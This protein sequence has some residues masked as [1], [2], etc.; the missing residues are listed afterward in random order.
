MC[1]VIRGKKILTPAL[2]IQIRK[3]LSL[4]LPSGA[5]SFLDIFVIATSLFFIGKIDAF[6]IVAIGVSLN[7]LMLFF[8]INA[9][10]YIG[11]NAQISR[12]FG[13]KEYQ[14]AKDVFS[15]L[16]I[17]G[18]LISFPLIPLAYFGSQNFFTYLKIQEH[19][20]ALAHTYISFI[21]FTIPSLMLKT[22]I[23][24]ALAGIGDT[25]H[26]FLVRLFSTILC[27]VLNY[28]FIFGFLFIPPLGIFGAGLATLISA[29]IELFALSIM[30]YLKSDFLK[31]FRFRKQY[32]IK[33]LKIGTPAGI[34][35]FLTLFSLVLTTKFIALFG[36]LALAGT[37]I[38]TRIEAF[39][40][41][42]GF[43]FM[44]AAMVLMGQNLGAKKPKVAALYIRT[45]L[46]FSSITLGILGLILVCFAHPFSSIFS[47]NTTV[48]NVS[49]SYLIAVGLSQVPMICSFVYDGA[50][51]GSGF[52]QSVLLINGISIWVFRMLPIWILVHFNCKIQWIFVVIFIETYIRAIIFHF[53]FKTGIWK[54]RQI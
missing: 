39:S 50:L 9:I 47:K 19:T 26:P 18:F 49:I 37:Q 35:R 30:L 27:V 22:I 21:I 14:K 33:A 40:F 32:L 52:S 44:T 41:M 8:A 31:S 13:A 29:Y 5:N 2:K 15:S 1:R 48:I 10:F 28:L 36:D 34:E 53:I 38:G 25:L 43:G 54:N 42:P 51:R 11:T 6:H 7:F 20:Q 45:I 4:A 3:I 23:I 12:Y 17:G 24:S 46:I 16:M